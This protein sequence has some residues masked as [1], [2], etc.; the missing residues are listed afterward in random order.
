MPAWEWA[1]ENK[2]DPS[3]LLEGT[4]LDGAQISETKCLLTTVQHYRL[5]N[6]IIA[7]G[8]DRAMGL[9]IGRRAHLSS[10][11]LLGM[12]MLCAP[13]VRVA[14]R[15]GATYAPVAGSLGK[16]ANR[17]DADGFAI[18]YSA[19]PVGVS[20][21]RYLTEDIFSA[22]L[23]YLSELM[24]EAP[25]GEGQRGWIRKVAFSYKRPARAD[26]YEARFQCPLEFGAKASCMWLE[27][28]LVE[29]VPVLSNALAFEQCLEMYERLLVDMK[30]EAAIVSRTRE[31][32]MRD[33]SRFLSVE[34]VAEAVELPPRT[35][36]RH[37]A[38]SG[39]SFGGVQADVRRAL[40][41][42][43]L[44]NST[45][46][47]EEIAAHLGYSE[48]SN[49]RRAFRSW[50]DVTPTAFRLAVTSRH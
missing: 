44:C 13:S 1:T 49:F 14:L 46:T 20:L 37:L 6:N 2:V 12:M 43:L 7:L 34:Q 10:I 15:V 31:I 11:G 28:A 38:R 5:V 16:L 36:Q 23:A 9:E 26:D 47:V 39:V 8:H 27:P 50:L 42:D 45:L 48:P 17:D 41:Q 18:I 33:P 4:G 3:L 24:N 40:A 25:P 19:P 29:K 35:F 30:E 22:T 21:R 32:I